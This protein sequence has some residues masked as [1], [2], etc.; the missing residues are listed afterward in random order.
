ML[1]PL[2]EEQLK[3]LKITLEKINLANKLGLDNDKSLDDLM[4]LTSNTG[5]KS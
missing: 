1:K 4:Q 2:T 3:I 5:D